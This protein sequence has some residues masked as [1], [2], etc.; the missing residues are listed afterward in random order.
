MPSGLGLGQPLEKKYKPAIRAAM[1]AEH[2]KVLDA[3]EERINARKQAYIEILVAS[4][5]APMDEDEREEHLLRMVEDKIGILG[6]DLEFLRNY[7]Q[8]LKDEIDDEKALVGISPKMVQDEIRA[9]NKAI[10]HQ[11]RDGYVYQATARSEI[12][13]WRQS[14]S[15]QNRTENDFTSYVDHMVS[16]EKVP[17]GATVGKKD[18]QWIEKQ[19]PLWRNKLLERYDA[20]KEIEK[21][22]EKGKGKGKDKEK[23]KGKGKDKEKE[24]GKEKQVWCAIAR[25]WFPS[26][27][28][29]AAHFAPTNNNEEELQHAFGDAEPNSN[30]QFN[31]RNGILIHRMFENLL[32]GGAIVLLP[33]FPDDRDPVGEDEWVPKED[34]WK[35]AVLWGGYQKVQTLRDAYGDVFKDFPVAN[36]HGRL[37]GFRTKNRPGRRYVWFR[38]AMNI[39]RRENF[40]IPN[41]E[42]DVKYYG[43]YWG[44]PGKHMRKST[45]KKMAH[46]LAH[47]DRV[48]ALA[49]FTAEDVPPDKEDEKKNDEKKNE[50][51]CNEEAFSMHAGTLI[52]LGKDPPPPEDWIQGHKYSP[53]KSAGK[54]GK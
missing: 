15:L 2:R 26:E 7:L 5:G 36:L 48:G 35:V 14:R 52:D 42:E 32:D 11:L 45:L 37:L 18:K 47:T 17:W 3:C 31:E 28:V 6:N 46:C 4:R 30:H 29:K 1:S 53:A 27:Q 43:Q 22:S 33:A 51:L 54:G 24:R 40:R 9:V 50:R 49:E 25:K 34:R 10:F 20:E 16:K 23:G 38:F 21:E 8:F 13:Q 41:Y 12:G 39:L 44:T 19:R